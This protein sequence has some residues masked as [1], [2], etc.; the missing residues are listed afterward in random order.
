MTILIT[1]DIN[2]FILNLD[3]NTFK[4]KIHTSIN[5]RKKYY[6]IKYDFQNDFNRR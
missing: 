1:A 6:E 4:N 3:V 2:K 5:E